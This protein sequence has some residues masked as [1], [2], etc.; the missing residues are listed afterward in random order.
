MRKEQWEGIAV[1]GVFGAIGGAMG[2]AALGSLVGMS[3]ALLIVA[4]PQFKQ[5]KR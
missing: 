3:L 5:E 1:G 4:L 2:S